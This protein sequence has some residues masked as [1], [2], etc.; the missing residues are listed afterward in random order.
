MV[1]KLKDTITLRHGATL[2]NRIVMSPMLT[3]S[4][5]RGGFASEDTISYYSAR[6]QAAAMLITEFHYV[7][8]KGGPASPPGYPEQ[9][10]AYSDRHIEGLTKIAHELKKDGNKAILQIHHGGREAI[11]Q[12]VSGEDVLAP[13]AIDFP[14]LKYPVK[15]LSHQ[16]ILE[17]IADFGRATKRAIAAGFDGVEI[18]GANHYLLQQF[19]SKTSNHRTDQWGGNLEKRMAFPLA[20]VEEVTRVATQEAP[21]SFI[22]GYRISP[23][24]IH[25]SDIGYD[26]EESMQLISEIVKYELDYIHLSLWGG[27]S[28]GPVNSDRSYAD[29]FKEVLDDQTK[30][31]VVG[32]VFSEESARN[33]VEE[34]TD[35]IAVARG[36]LIEPQFAKKVIEDQGNT[37]FHE[38]TPENMEYVNWTAGLKEALSRKDSVGLPLLPGGESIRSLHT[39]RF[40]MFYRK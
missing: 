2:S 20:V 23:E 35:L 19:F 40:D 8:E 29:L 24:E 7:S 34:Y 9:L 32:G 36:T 15:E 38:I 28:S 10:G 4:G 33:A 26:Y 11:G 3:Y 6:S 25:D 37:I 18:H 39:G 27:Y 14:F 16:E 30:L 21:E 1:N 13:S 17:I 22:I 31:V 12:A 5:K